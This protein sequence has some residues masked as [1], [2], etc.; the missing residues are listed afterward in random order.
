MTWEMENSYFRQSV[1]PL[2]VSSRLHTGI[3]AGNK[4]QAFILPSKAA[5]E[6]EALTQAAGNPF[7]SLT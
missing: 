7:L 1:I 2:V 6:N 5:K 4:H 3:V